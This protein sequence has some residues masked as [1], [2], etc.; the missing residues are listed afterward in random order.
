MSTPRCSKATLQRTEEVA[1]LAVRP[2]RGEAT[3]RYGEVLRHI[4]GEGALRCGEE[5]RF[6]PSFPSFCTFTISSKNPEN[7]KTKHGN[8][9]Q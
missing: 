8:H 3:L 6:L 1:F 5:A 9:S 2:R 7:H 4:E